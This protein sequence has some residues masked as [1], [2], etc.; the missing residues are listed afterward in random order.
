M[1]SQK[2]DTELRQIKTLKFVAEYG[3]DITQKVHAWVQGPSGDWS[4]ERAAGWSIVCRVAS[5]FYGTKGKRHDWPKAKGFRAMRGCIGVWVID[6]SYLTK[7]I[8]CIF[9][10]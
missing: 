9:L 10:S 2:L 7:G 1:V 4:S 5:F 6:T 3:K 8:L